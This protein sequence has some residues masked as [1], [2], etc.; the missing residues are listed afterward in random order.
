MSRQGHRELAP[1]AKYPIFLTG[2]EKR[3]RALSNISLSF[4]RRR[5]AAFHE[6]IPMFAPISGKSDFGEADLTASPSE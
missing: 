6:N 1:P 3:C 2:S 4:H 5:R